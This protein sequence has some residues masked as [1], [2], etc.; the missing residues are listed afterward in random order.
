MISNGYG[1]ASQAWS[2]G[3][4]PLA[5]PEPGGPSFQSWLVM[6]LLATLLLFGASGLLYHVAASDDFRV[7]TVAVTGSQLVPVAEIEQVAAAGGLNIFWVRQE[8]VGQRLQTISAI[9]S[10]RV[11][12]ALPNRLELQIVERAPVALWRA[13]ETAFLVDADGRVLRST[14]RDVSLPTIRDL[15]A[16]PVQAGGTIDPKALGTMFRLQQL[17]PQVA[18]LR[19]REFEYSPETGV[20]VVGESGSRMRFGLDDDLEWKVAALAAIRRDLDRQGQRPELIDVRFKDRP[21][22]R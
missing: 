1:G 17:L 5:R 21:Y 4:V 15:G 8:E 19:P 14:D 20:T 9:Q 13:G 11:S 6:K 2:T 7:T 12:T 10:A 22:V 18:A 16:R 3:D